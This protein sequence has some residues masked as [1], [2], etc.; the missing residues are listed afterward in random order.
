MNETAL[1]TA[2]AVAVPLWIEDL[3][4]M[5]WDYIQQRAKICS[6]VVAEKG[7]VILFRGGKKGE[8]AEAFNR[9]AEGVA[10]LSFAPGGVRVFGEHWV[11]KLEREVL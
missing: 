2:L 8:S 3:K 9:L 4:H 1:A 11:G 7:D 6:D 10:C 5:P